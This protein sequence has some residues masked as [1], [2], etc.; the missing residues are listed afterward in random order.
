[1]TNRRGS[2]R[3]PW[4]GLTAAVAGRSSQSTWAVI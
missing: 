3:P 1:M 4:S 2:A